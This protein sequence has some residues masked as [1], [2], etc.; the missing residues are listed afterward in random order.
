MYTQQICV[1][2]ITYIYI[3]ISGGAPVMGAPPPR[4]PATIALAIVTNNRSRYLLFLDFVKFRGSQYFINGGGL[5]MQG[6]Y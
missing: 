5:L 6:V 1:Y 2:N 4:P 3:Y